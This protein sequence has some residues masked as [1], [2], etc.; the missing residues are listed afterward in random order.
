MILSKLEISGFRSVAR[1]LELHVSD[2]LTC[3][4]GANEHGKSNI[5]QALNLM[6]S[7]EFGE[8]DKYVHSKRDDDPHLVFSVQ[9]S[10]TE[11]KSLTRAV[12]GQLDGL[13]STESEEDSDNAEGHRSAIDH[14]QSLA[15]AEVCLEVDSDSGRHLIVD[16]IDFDLSSGPISD[17]LEENI[18]QV[19]LF[20]PT[21]SLAD[22]ITL[23]QLK[24]KANLPFVGL[25]KLAD[26]W[27]NVD[28]LFEGGNA[29]HRNLQRVGKT[30]TRKLRKIWSQGAAH[31]IRLD[32]SSGTLHIG[33]EDPT[34]FD[35]PSRRSLGFQSFLSFYLAIY[36]E[37]D[38]FDPEGFILLFD[39][40]GI[41]LHPRGQK[42]LL[43]ELRKLSQRNQ[44][45]YT[46]HS[47]FMIDRN[48]PLNTVLVRKGLTGD[49]KGTHLVSKP[50]GENWGALNR[51]LGITPSDGF[52][53]A[54]RVLLVE[55]RSDR[56]YVHYYMALL[57]QQTQADLNDFS[58]VDCER[59]EEIEGYVKLLLASD[60]KIVV[61]ADGDQGGDDLGRRISRIAGR[62]GDQV[63]FIDLRKILASS[64]DVSL[65]DALP[66]TLWFAA[67]QEYVDRTLKAKHTVDLT[68]VEALSKS[69]S[70]GRAA[71]DYL[72]E[73]KVL[74]SSRNFSKTTVAD[75]FCRA[76]VQK[77]DQDGP[78]VKLCLKITLELG[79]QL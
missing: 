70:L 64:K 65:E 63:S 77:P 33:I 52:F 60:R 16:E 53:P 17:W 40:P 51:E 39:E 28:A 59:R 20:E 61:L 66:K 35:M 57:Q 49:R 13:G 74:A 15:K 43:R 19:R 38:E 76:R 10:N 12:Q 54:D 26:A 58:I 50:Y 69:R 22:S 41:H 75:F 34:T 62:K 24:A 8:N 29:A 72:A 25:L 67:L 30:L 68:R 79:I 3:L 73:M 48:N 42:D 78:M 7:G 31:S 32:E 46:T 2:S 18:P 56:I 36:A 4:V 14:L 44:I 23:S 11:T 9:L 6:D 37:T 47:P 21:E 71:A 27:D 5:L 1:E 45:I 55:G